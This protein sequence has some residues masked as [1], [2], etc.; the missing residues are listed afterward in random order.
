[1][2]I[3]IL[4][5]YIQ[6]NDPWASLT[7]LESPLKLSCLEP[8]GVLCY[9]LLS[10]TLFYLKNLNNPL[11]LLRYIFIYFYCKS[12]K[13]HRGKRNNRHW[14]HKKLD[15]FVSGSLTG[16]MNW[17]HGKY[18]RLQIKE[19]DIE[20]KFSEIHFVLFSVHGPQI[21]P[22]DIKIALSFWIF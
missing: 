8:S 21:E 12:L 22:L 6:E 1:M 20:Y 17:T 11:W 3:N 18:L 2:P 4:I 5:S 10:P 19:L 13:Q 9:Q 16:A 7:L 14:T 15:K